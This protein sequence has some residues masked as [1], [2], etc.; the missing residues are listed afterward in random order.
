MSQ[1]PNARIVSRSITVNAPGVSLSACGNRD[2]ESTVGRSSKNALYEPDCAFTLLTIITTAQM[3]IQAC[4]LVSA[5]HV[6]R[7]PFIFVSSDRM[8]P[9]CVK[10]TVVSA[11][12]HRPKG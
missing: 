11:K 3:L 6:A 7:I 2:A 10:R 8:L 1:Y 4:T 12:S 5:E 9:T